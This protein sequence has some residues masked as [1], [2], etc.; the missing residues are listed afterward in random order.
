M[1]IVS[2]LVS[3]FSNSLIVVQW[4]AG[5]LAIVAAVAS[6]ASVVRHWNKGH[7]L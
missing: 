1:S 6:V 7:G 3:F 2:G 5:V 4:F